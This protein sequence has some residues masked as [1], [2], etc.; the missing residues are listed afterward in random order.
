[1]RNKYILLRHGETKYQEEN[2]PVIYSKEENPTIPLTGNGKEKIKKVAKELKTKSI[3]LI[4][5]S[6]FKRAEQ[7]ASII[8]EELGLK[9]N[10]DKR[11][12][13]TDFGIFHGR[14]ITEYYDYFTKEKDRFLERS[15]QG[16]NWT[17]VQERVLEFIK[18]I[19]KKYKDKKILIV[20]H[21]DP[22]WLLA[23]FLKQVN[24]KEL[25][26]KRHNSFGEYKGFYATTGQ[27]IEP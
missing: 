24:N 8:A 25:A 5:S 19:D 1:M 13:D 9:V 15:P 11:L 23:G 20:S 10:F 2:I 14:P 6:P 4:Y 12:I 16:E 3:D 18:E 27:F 22:I 7:T 17:D 21:G 26:K